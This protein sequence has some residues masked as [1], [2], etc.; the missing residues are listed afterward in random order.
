M[1]KV[2]ICI[3]IYILGILTPIMFNVIHKKN[4]ENRVIYKVRITA[5]VI[6]LRKEIDLKGEIIMEVYKDEEF[7]VVKY[8]EGNAYNWYQIIYEEGKTGWVAS[9]KTNSW[10]EVVE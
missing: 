4:L 7:E 10:V 1:K 6:N 5:P 2:L 9:G 3:A 8:H